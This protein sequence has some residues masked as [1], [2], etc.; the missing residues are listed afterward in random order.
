MVPTGAEWDAA[1]EKWRDLKS[2]EGAKF[3]KEVI[4]NGADIP[5]TVTWGTSPQDTAPV[6]GFVPDPKVDSNGDAAREAGMTRSLE[7]MGLT[8]KEKIDEIAVRPHARPLRARCAPVAR[9]LHT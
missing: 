6:T 9:L 8:A 1:V 7:Y 5:P 4:I 3:D 2:D